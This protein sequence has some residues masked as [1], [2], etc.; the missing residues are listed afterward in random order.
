MEIKLEKIEF[1]T[2]RRSVIF[3]YGSEVA[4]RSLPFK[5]EESAYVEERRKRDI[6]SLVVLNRLPQK[7]YV[8]NFD[9]EKPSG[10]T[11]ESLRK[12]AAELQLMLAKEGVTSVAITGEGVIPEEVVA[13]V[14]GLAM[15]SYRFDKYKAKKDTLLEE[16][17]VSSHILDPKSLEENVRLWRRINVLRDWVNEPVMYLNAPTFADMLKAE[18]DKVAGVKC[19][20]MGQKKI[21]SLKMGGLLAVNRGSEDEAR[22][23][24]LEYKPADRVN[25]KP[26]ALV[27]KGVMYDTGGLN[28][29][30][31]DYMTEMKS[32]MAGAATIF[33]VCMTALRWR[34]RT[35]TPRAV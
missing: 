1:G 19:T 16:I 27:G 7:I 22:F 10:E 35:P 23:V 2:L 15:A 30:P 14:E 17:V 25:K 28:I 26:V 21:E 9:S 11:L 24:V 32:D 20:V 6:S 31:E 13:F 4:M 12:A 29:K 8:Q 33:C 18:A 34:L 3:L 5:R